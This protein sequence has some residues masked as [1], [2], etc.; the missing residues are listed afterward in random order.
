[1]SGIEKGGLV[2]YEGIG[3]NTEKKES[4]IVKNYG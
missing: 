4:P 2:Y 3:N 1:M